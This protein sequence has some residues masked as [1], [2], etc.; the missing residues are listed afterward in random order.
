MVGFLSMR[1]YVHATK[2]AKSGIV[3]KFEDYMKSA[4]I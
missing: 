3:Q 2:E 1:I 4:V